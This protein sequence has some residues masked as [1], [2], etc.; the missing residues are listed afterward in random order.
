MILAWVLNVISDGEGTLTPAH[1]QVIVKVPW[2]FGSSQA[3]TRASFVWVRINAFISKALFT[4]PV[5]ALQVGEPIVGFVEPTNGDSKSAQLVS[6]SP[7]DLDTWRCQAAASFPNYWETH[8]DALFPIP[9]LHSAN[10]EYLRPPHLHAGIFVAPHLSTVLSTPSNPSPLLATQLSA[11]YVAQDQLYGVD[12]S[13][14]VPV[15]HRGRSTVRESEQPTYAQAGSSNDFWI[16][17]GLDVHISYSSHNFHLLGQ[18][19][20]FPQ[21][22]TLILTPIY[23]Q[24]RLRGWHG[25]RAAALTLVVKKTK[26]RGSEG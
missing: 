22:G 17:E 21:K 11:Q 26:L 9:Q 6:W 8:V 15:P 14:P 18:K 4:T 12:L 25:K 7:T 20:W 2:R 16:F 3:E 24:L 5:R 13:K 10:F 19:K 23:K 1:V